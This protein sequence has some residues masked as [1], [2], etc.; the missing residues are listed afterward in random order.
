M[1]HKM[2][3]KKNKESVEEKKPGPLTRLWE[4]TGI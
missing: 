2:T 3:K 1:V 4:Q